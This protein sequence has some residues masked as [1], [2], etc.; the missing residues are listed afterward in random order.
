MRTV[1]VNPNPT[2]SRNLNPNPH[3]DPDPTDA[4]CWLSQAGVVGGGLSQASI[5]ATAALEE[6]TAAAAEQQALSNIVA[7]CPFDTTPRTFYFQVAVEESLGPSEETVEVVGG[8][9]GGSRHLLKGAGEAIEEEEEEELS[10]Q[11]LAG[12]DTT[13]EFVEQK[14]GESIT[15][16]SSPAMKPHG[17]MLACI[18]V[19]L[20]RPTH[21]HTRMQ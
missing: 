5:A 1:I 11:E 3:P 17:E 4:V 13:R 16:V 2:L 14:W 9:A 15:K 8:G 21:R 10:L 18:S 20:S 12:V 19:R 6:S 7:A